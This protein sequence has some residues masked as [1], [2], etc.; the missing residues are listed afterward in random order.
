MEIDSIEGVGHDR[1][2]LQDYST[3]FFGGVL[4]E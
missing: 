2:A 1:K 4:K 3:Q